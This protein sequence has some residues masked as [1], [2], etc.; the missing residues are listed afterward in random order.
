MR[1]RSLILAF[2]LASIPAGGAP[3]QSDTLA[4]ELA[5][6]NALLSAH[7]GGH[8]IVLDV[9]FASPG[10]APPSMTTTPRP[11]TRQ[12]ALEDAIGPLNAS[13]STDTL[14]V[15]AS[16]PIFQGSVATVSITVSHRGRAGRR[17]RFYET[18][19]YQLGRES[20]RWVIQRRSQLGIS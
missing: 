17:R 5:A 14:Y 11:V 8:V 7:A 6:I 2:A 1:M 13:A 12:R 20:G 3:A 4:V 15:Q 16:A 19:E 9:R 18:I 10:Q